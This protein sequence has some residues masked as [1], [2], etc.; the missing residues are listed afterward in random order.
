[1]AS[2]SL[3]ALSVFILILFFI[4][5]CDQISRAVTVYTPHDPDHTSETYDYACAK[6]ANEYA[7]E[8]EVIAERMNKM[9]CT[10]QERINNNPSLYYECKDLEVEQRS[11]IILWKDLPCVDPSRV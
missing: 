9:G 4:A 3:G 7:I 5:G 11:Y 2:N 1:M 6:K 8:T 10:N